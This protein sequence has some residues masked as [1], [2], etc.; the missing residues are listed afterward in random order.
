MS[1]QIKQME[2]DA[3]GKTFRGVRD[4][5]ALSVVGLD[6]RAD[7]QLRLALRKKNIR[8]QVVKNSLTRRVFG[9]LGLNATKIWEGPTTLA[10]GAT[11][12]AELSRELDTALGKNPKVKFKGAVADGQEVTFEQAKKMPTKAEA[13]GRVVMLALA[14]A[15]RLVSQIRGPAAQVASQIKTLSEKAEGEKAAEAAPAPTA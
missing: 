14:P 1:K 10:W 2:M 4:L 7:N 12:L 3:L 6:S 15:G 9:E 13:I 5:V 11:S 8:L